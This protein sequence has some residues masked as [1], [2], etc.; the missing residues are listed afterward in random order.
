MPKFCFSIEQ[1]QDVGWCPPNMSLEWT[2][3]HR[4]IASD[5]HSLPAT[6]GQR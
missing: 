5:V 6:Q 3:H 4:F 1:V 2:G